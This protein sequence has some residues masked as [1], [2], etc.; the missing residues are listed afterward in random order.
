MVYVTLNTI[1]NVV[2]HSEEGMQPFYTH[3]TTK[4]LIC[5]QEGQLADYQA[6]VGYTPSAR[7]LRYVMMHLWAIGIEQ[8]T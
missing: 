1:N 7:C 3:A 4:W 6:F 5:G 8:T 2:G